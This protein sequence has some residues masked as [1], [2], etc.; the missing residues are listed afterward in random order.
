LI[1]LLVTGPDAKKVLGVSRELDRSLKSKMSQQ[2]L[3]PA[4]AAIPKLRN[5]WRYHLLLKGKT[6]KEM[7]AAAAAA[8]EETAVPAEVKIMVDVEPMGML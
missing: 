8:L 7:R 6:L 1:S 5:E 4:P 2:V 3:G